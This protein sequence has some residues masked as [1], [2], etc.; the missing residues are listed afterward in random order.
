MD[1]KLG[2]HAKDGIEVID[3]QGEIDMYT[4]PRA[5]V[6]VRARAGPLPHSATFHY[7]AYAECSGC[8]Q[9]RHHPGW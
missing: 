1:L 7:Q 3:V 4:A 5:G 6:V 9:G 8:R 2:H